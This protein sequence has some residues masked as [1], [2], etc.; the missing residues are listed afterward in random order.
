[1]GTTPAQAWLNS[2]KVFFKSE[3]PTFVI[4]CMIKIMPKN[5]KVDAETVY[6]AAR[7]QDSK[8][9]T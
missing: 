9:R 5:W 1:M 2:H 6:Q 8:L 3:A 4:K 7:E